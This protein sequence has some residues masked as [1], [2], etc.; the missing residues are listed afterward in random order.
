MLETYE[1]VGEKE[2]FARPEKV[3]ESS[4]IAKRIPIGL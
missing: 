3:I 1:T 4:T 2:M